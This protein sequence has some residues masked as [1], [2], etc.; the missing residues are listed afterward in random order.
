[1][2]SV[3]RG[4]GGKGSI[5]DIL[6]SAAQGDVRN[7]QFQQAALT[8]EQER[9]RFNQLIQQVLSNLGGGLMGVVGDP[10]NPIAGIKAQGDRLTIDVG[11]QGE[12]GRS[13]LQNQNEW[14]LDKRS[15]GMFGSLM[16][17]VGG[18]F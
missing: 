14:T 18:T 10:D 1:M 16:G 13:A 9:K 11:P 8:R 2:A 17:N 12:G 6:G 5:G 7:K 4:L 3:G 15:T